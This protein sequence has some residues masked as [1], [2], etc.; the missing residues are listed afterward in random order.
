MY[1]YTSNSSIVSILH[2][3]T[4]IC[5]C[6]SGQLDLVHDWL[7]RVFVNGDGGG[8]DPRLGSHVT[9]TNIRIPTVSHKSSRLILITAKT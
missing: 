6:A 2:V 4:I 5:S 1:I 7:F 3:V 8:V 9:K